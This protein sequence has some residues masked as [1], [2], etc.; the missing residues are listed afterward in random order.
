[1][2]DIKHSFPRFVWHP[3]YGNDPSYFEPEK[4][5]RE[6]G[7]LHANA[8]HWHAIGSS[9]R[10]CWAFY[11]SKIIETFPMMKDRDY[12]AEMVEAAHKRKINV[13]AYVNVHWAPDKFF[14]DHPGWGQ[15]KADGTSCG[16]GYGYGN[17]ICSDNEEYRNEWVIPI[18]KEVLSAYDVDGLFLDGPARYLGGCYCKSCKDKFRARFNLEMPEEIDWNDP[19][20]RN[21]VKFNYW[22]EDDF[23][24]TIRNVAHS[25]RPDIPVYKNGT[26]LKTT[27][28]NGVDVTRN[29]Q[30]ADMIG[31]ESFL[32]G[33]RPLDVPCWK[34]G[35]VSKYLYSA[36]QGKPRCNYLKYAHSP[37]HASPLSADQIKHN[38]ADTIANGAF[39][40]MTIEDLAMH[41]KRR[42]SAISEMYEMIEKNEKYY[43]NAKSVARIGLLWSIT[44]SDYY[45][46][47]LKHEADGTHDY[48]T[49]AQRVYV[50]EFRGF[51]EALLQSGLPFDLISQA[52]LSDE[53]LAK[54]KVLV[55]PNAACISDSQARAI[56]NFVEQGGTVLA[57]YETSFYDEEGLLR[58]KPALSSVLG[59]AEVGETLPPTKTDYMQTATKHPV[60]GVMEDG[61]LIVLPCRN[62]CVTASEEDSIV[63]RILAHRPYGY[64]PYGK[65]TPYPAVMVNQGKG[66]GRSVYFSGLVG[67]HYWE[68]RLPDH[69]ELICNT[70]EWLGAPNPVKLSGSRNV[71]V[72]AFAQEDRLIIHLVNFTA[73]AAS[74]PFS[75]ISP[76]R[77]L[78]LFIASELVKNPKRVFS[79]ITDKDLRYEPHPDGIVIHIPEIHIYEA[80]SIG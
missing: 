23:L 42:Y 32:Y 77:D 49:V 8:I 19:N 45:E 78:D 61:A 17:A 58:K 62:I 38:I 6:A 4:I 80:I 3:L 54:F 53:G 13:V 57:T 28:F 14:E 5:A 20:W 2:L 34:P 12:L 24:K 76:V 21:L 47:A 7:E 30:S 10:S 50:P 35:G 66:K 69:R 72:T 33:I 18:V 15:I 40:F 1:M 71:E 74:L 73:R 46:R 22:S 67:E 60:L 39:P 36:S 59:I 27:W 16:G 79:I 68:Y 65:A 63:A 9:S 31:A 75:E 11:Q 41:D 51:Y 29:T 70:I 25:I 55:L 64:S 52:N 43:V 26:V 48:S 37:W 56:K 44:T